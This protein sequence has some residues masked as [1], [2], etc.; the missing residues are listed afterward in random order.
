M[1]VRQTM[2]KSWCIRGIR[3]LEGTR[4]GRV[5]GGRTRARME[6]AVERGEDKR[7][8]DRED[9]ESANETERTGEAGV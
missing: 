9:R 6:R 8:R 3:A 7:K 2:R 5:E 1:R 4:V